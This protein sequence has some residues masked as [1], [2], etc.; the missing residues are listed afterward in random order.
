MDTRYTLSGGRFTI[1][2]PKDKDIAQ[3][4]CKAT[5][6]YG[7]LLSKFAKIQFGCKYTCM[8]C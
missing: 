7:T 1:E 3:Y 4:R 6:E 5:N 2:D 8:S